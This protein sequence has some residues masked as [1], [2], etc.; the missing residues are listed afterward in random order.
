MNA[1]TTYIVTKCISLAIAIVYLIAVVII[2]LQRKSSS[3]LLSW[4]GHAKKSPK[5]VAAPTLPQD[6]DLAHLLALANKDTAPP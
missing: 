4:T 1:N 5:P 3:G 6:E 2:S